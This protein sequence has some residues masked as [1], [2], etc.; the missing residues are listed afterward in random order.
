MHVNTNKQQIEMKP[1]YLKEAV[2]LR[3]DQIGEQQ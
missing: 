3:P 2:K 1:V